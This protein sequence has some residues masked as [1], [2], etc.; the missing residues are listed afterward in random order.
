MKKCIGPGAIAALAVVGMASSAFAGSATL[1]VDSA[2]GSA[3]SPRDKAHSD[4]VTSTTLVQGFTLAADSTL[5][6]AALRGFSAGA[7]VTIAITDAMG[8]GATASNVL[9]EQSFNVV[10]DGV[11][12]SMHSFNLGGLNLD[13][14]SYYFVLMSSD[15]VGFEWARVSP[16]GLGVDHRGDSTYSVGAPY[17]TQAYNF[18]NGVSDQ[19]YV[20]DITGS[21]IPTPG[22][23]SL[24]ALGGLTASRR[25][26]R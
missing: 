5:D 24:L 15:S 7:D 9:F 6:Y 12:S 22:A 25:K 13:S 8:V 20:L 17:L 2:N 21:E 14:G 23:A 18:H 26:R 11:G 1:L 10:A 4:E 3:F 19:V 16:G